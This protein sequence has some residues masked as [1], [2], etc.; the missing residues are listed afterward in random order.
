MVQE[1]VRTPWMYDLL[2]KG[3]I[4][5]TLTK[6]STVTFSDVDIANAN[7]AAITCLTQ[8]GI[9]NGMSVGC[10][11]PN[12]SFNPKYFDLVLKRFTDSF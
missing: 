1:N 6:K 12:D 8:A 10:F 9:L 2:G 3:N 7:Y 11:Y 5:A 4:T